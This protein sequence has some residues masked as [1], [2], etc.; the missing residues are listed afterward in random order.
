MYGNEIINFYIMYFDFFKQTLKYLDE[1][2]QHIIDRDSL[3]V[4]EQF[5]EFNIISDKNINGFFNIDNFTLTIN[6][7]KINEIPLT[8]NSKI[9]LNNQDRD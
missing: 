3:P 5:V 2:N 8:I 9:I 4:L 1:S 7:N 6:F